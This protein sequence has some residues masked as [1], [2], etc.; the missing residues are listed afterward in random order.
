MILN[1]TDK[2]NLIFLDYIVD[3]INLCI[4]DNC[5]YIYSNNIKISKI[6]LENI[7]EKLDSLI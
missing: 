5:E 4:N 2:E 7:K 6:E 1:L 3:M